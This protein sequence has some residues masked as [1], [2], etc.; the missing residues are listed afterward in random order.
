MVLRQN[1]L[2]KS[3]N[4]DEQSCA[5]ET[6]ASHAEIGV[7]SLEKVLDI[8]RTVVAEAQSSGPLYIVCHDERM[9]R[10]YVAQAA[11]GRLQDGQ[12]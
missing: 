5:A 4:N 1:N 6:T 12:S 10:K 11:Y 8:I 9:E 2:V 3:G 7:L